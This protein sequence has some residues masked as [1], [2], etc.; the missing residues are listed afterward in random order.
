MPKNIKQELEDSI[1]DHITMSG[2]QKQ[3]ILTEAAKRLERKP[4]H[5]SRLILPLVSAAAILGLSGILAAPYVQEEMK[6]SEVRQQLDDT[7]EKVTV[8]DANYPSLVNS[9][10]VEETKELVYTDG[11]GFYSFNKE[12]KTTE[13]LVKP[14]EGAGLYEFAVNGDWLVWDTQVKGYAL[15]RQTHEIEE[16]PGELF[17]DYQVYGNLLS[18]LSVGTDDQFTGYK[19]LDLLTLHQSNLHELTGEGTSSQ[20]SLNDGY[21]VIPETIV[22]NEEKNILFTLYDLKGR[23]EEREFKVPYEQ[24]VNVTLTDDKIYAELSNE[25]RSPGLAYISLDDGEVHKVKAPS[26]D[27]YAVYEDYL[28]LSIPEKEDSNTVKLY[29]IVDDSAEALPAFEH[30]EERLVK[31]RF[32]DDGLLVVN[33]EG[34]DISMYLLDTEKIKN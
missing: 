11:K 19:L 29:R 31:P 28:A 16:I 23:E 6:E 14:E 7:L 10:Y 21:I 3:K 17:G 15:N 27:A 8:P 9:Q 20:A 32:T 25:G 30:V 4:R 33:G 34:E 2:R 26:F 13:T 12:T 22:E 1:P 24:A 5:S 18:Y